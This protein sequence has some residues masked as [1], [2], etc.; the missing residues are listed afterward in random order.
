MV[1]INKF[2]S[3]LALSFITYLAG[4]ASASAISLNLNWTGTGDTDPT[5]IY[6]LTGSFEGNDNNADGFIRDGF[7]RSGEITG[8]NINFFK[9][10]TILA[11]YNFSTISSDGQFNFNYEI[12]TNTILQTGDL[13][14][15]T[16]F[17][18]GDSSTGG[19]SLD[20]GITSPVILSFNDN[21]GGL[22]S[23]NGG[24]LTA[25]PVPFEFEGSA[26]ILTIGAIWGI[27]KWRKNRIKK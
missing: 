10:S 17:S 21:T 25:M 16:G 12:A 4:T 11:S 27:N 9:N 23:A 22:N 18:I 14:S 5:D 2:L 15:L 7:I 3:A 20:T 1:K 8:F 26:G 13:A 19:Y 6:S 24:T